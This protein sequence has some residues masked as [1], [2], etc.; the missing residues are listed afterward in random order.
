MWE[1]A[2]VVLVF[3]NLTLFSTV[4]PFPSHLLRLN[5]IG[6]AVSR[7]LSLR[8]LLFL[9]HALWKLMRNESDKKGGLVGAIS[10]YGMESGKEERGIINTD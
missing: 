2:V 9:S 5:K 3:L 8:N 6:A 4:A 1:K 7:E 10:A